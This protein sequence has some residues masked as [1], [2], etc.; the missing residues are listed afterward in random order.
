MEVK[1]KAYTPEADDV[2]GVAAGTCVSEHIP[3]RG[4]VYGE[5]SKNANVLRHALDSGHE[6]VAEHA[7]FTFA[8]EGISRACSHQLSFSRNMVK[9]I[10]L[11]LG[12]Q[13]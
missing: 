12:Y 6:S 13:P 4:Y 2:C 7:V 8:I 11:R 1:L 5:W 9:P 3:P 10:I